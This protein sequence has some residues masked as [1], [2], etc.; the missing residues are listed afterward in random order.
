MHTIM[1][2]DDNESELIIAQKALEKD[3]IIIPIS[4]SKQALARLAKATIMPSLILLDI[5]MPGINGFEIIMRLK[6][7]EKAKNIP[8]IFLSGS[9]DH[10]TELEAY[11]LGAV[12]FIR[13]PVVAELLHKRIE[14]QMRMI[15]HQKQMDEYNQQL[16]QM[17]SFQTQNAMRMEY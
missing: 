2:V 1:I 16:Q 13:R 11:R 9:P 4:N 12:D 8:V 7:S 14:M 15:D 17:A 10:A 6:I 5:A 3:Y